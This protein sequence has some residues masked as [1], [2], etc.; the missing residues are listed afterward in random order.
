MHHLHQHDIYETA[1]GYEVIYSVERSGKK[2][3]ITIPRYGVL[4]EPEEECSR[5]QIDNVARK[6]GE[7]LSHNLVSEVDRSRSA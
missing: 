4:D 6:L 2:I 3:K 5:E 1:D 7:V